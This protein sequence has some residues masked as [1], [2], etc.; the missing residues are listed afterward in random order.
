MVE[1]SFEDIGLDTEK[2][3]EF[4]ISDLEKQKF[5]EIT[6]DI[7]PLHNDKSFAQ[8]QGFADEVVYGMLT[9]SYLSTFAGVYLPG[10]YSIIHSVEI[11]FVKPVVLNDSPLKITGKVVAK[12]ERFGQITIKY[13]ITNRDGEKVCRGIMKVGL[14]NYNKN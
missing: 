4:I 14:S 10:K 8:K 1:L 5:L 6:G 13:N 11:N 2:S 9:A 3:F 12:D 7:N